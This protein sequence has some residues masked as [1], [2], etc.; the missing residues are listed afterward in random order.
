MTLANIEKELVKV[1]DKKTTKV[2]YAQFGNLTNIFPGIILEIDGQY[3]TILKFSMGIWVERWVP[4]EHL[5]IRTKNIS[6]LIFDSRK[7][8]IDE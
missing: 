1:S 8:I 2:W 5:F 4:V 7:S 3:A 6:D